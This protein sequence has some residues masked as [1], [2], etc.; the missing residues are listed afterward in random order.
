[1]STT[2][3][4]QCFP[5]WDHHEVLTVIPLGPC[6]E[7]DRL[8]RRYEGGPR[9]HLFRGDPRVVQEWLARRDAKELQADLALLVGPPVADMGPDE[10]P[11]PFMPDGSP[12]NP[13]EY[14]TVLID[15]RK[16]P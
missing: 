5:K 7:C 16:Q 3:C 15:A 4:E 6:C 10:A 13:S 12:A 9:V 11:Q 8:D 14:G 2:L 1:M